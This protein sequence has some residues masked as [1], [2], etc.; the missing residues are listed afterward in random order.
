MISD[1]NSD[2]VRYLKDLNKLRVDAL[3]DHARADYRY[4]SMTAVFLE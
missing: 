3:S 1:S 2:T 4:L